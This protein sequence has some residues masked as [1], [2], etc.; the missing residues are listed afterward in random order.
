MKNIFGPSRIV[1][2]ADSM[3]KL[4]EYNNI[5]AIITSL[6]DMEE[7]G[8]SLEGWIKWIENAC[9]ILMNQ[10]DDNGI[11]F[12][13]QTNRKY[14]GHII[15]KNSLITKAFIDNNYNKVL[16]KIVIK[17]KINTINLFRPSYT[18]LFAFSR[19]LKSGKPSPDVIESGKMIYKNAMGFNAVNLC[20]DYIEKYVDTS[21]IFDPFCGQG[22]VLKI[23]NIRGYDSLGID[24]LS[25]QCKKAEIL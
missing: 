11:I 20:I 18:N 10:L 16:S 24:I 19:N 13:Y 7:I 1:I 17:Q 4:K 9:I 8:Y 22:S 12:F 5:K 2:C 3:D 21:S 15:D 6:P 14:K 23:S 25:E